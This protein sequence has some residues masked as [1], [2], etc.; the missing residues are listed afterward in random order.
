MAVSI[1][2]GLI[3]AT[4]LTLVFVP[5][6]YVIINDIIGVFIDRDDLQDAGDIEK[7]SIS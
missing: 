7:K 2:F 5:S 3:A 1:S 6:L 4:F